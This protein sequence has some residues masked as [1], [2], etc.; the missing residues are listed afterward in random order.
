MQMNPSIFP[1]AKLSLYMV[2]SGPDG[3]WPAAVGRYIG[4]RSGVGGRKV[5][6]P[7]DVAMGNTHRP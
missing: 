4:L 6:A 3:R 1:L 7:Q 2:R 5:R